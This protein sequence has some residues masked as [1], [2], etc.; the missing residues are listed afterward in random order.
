M[1]LNEVQGVIVFSG[2]VMIFRSVVLV[3][4]IF[5]LEN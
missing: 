2:N 1:L 5:D 4:L 3:T